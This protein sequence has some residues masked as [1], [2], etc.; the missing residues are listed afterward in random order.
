VHRA[1][2]RIYAALAALG[3][4]LSSPS[5]SYAQMDLG[6][7]VE[8]TYGEGLPRDRTLLTINTRSGR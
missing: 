2:F 5:T 4:A 7:Q 3:V 6:P 1:Q 8:N